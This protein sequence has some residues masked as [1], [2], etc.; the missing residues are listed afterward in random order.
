[1]HTEAAGLTLSV[2]GSAAH[3]A[4][5]DGVRGADVLGQQLPVE[6]PAGADCGGQ[7]EDPRWE[8]VPDGGHR[9]GA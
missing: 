8:G 7:A 4:L 1:M 6:R 5:S 3:R 2:S 9:R